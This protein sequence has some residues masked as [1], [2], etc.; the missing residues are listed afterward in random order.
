MSGVLRLLLLAVLRRGGARCSRRASRM[1]DPAAVADEVV[2]TAPAAPADAAEAPADAGDGAPATPVREEQPTARGPD[3]GG[4]GPAADHRRDAPAAGD[5]SRRRRRRP[6]RPIVETAP[7]P[8]ASALPTTPDAP[9][10]IVEPDKLPVALLPVVRTSATAAPAATAPWCADVERAR[11]RTRRRSSAKAAAADTAPAAG[12]SRRAVER[13]TTFR[14]RRSSRWTR[15]QGRSPVAPVG[16]TAIERGPGM[17]FGEESHSTLFS[18][19]VAAPIG[20]VGSGSSLLAVLAGY[21]LPGVG[22]PPASTLIMFILV[23]L[24]VA[25]ARAPRPQLSERAHD[26]RP[27]G[28]RLRPRPGGLPTRLARTPRHTCARQRGRHRRDIA[29][30]AAPRSGPA[31][32]LREMWGTTRCSRCGSWFWDPRAPGAARSRRPSPAWATW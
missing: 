5:A 17:P 31:H 18:E 28:R 26:R 15:T 30:R 25:I 32:N 8:G 4:P 13:G 9:K 29:S 14:A 20:A 19:S 27:A 24:I 12:R 3:H 1:A 21:V 10:A 7:P 2:T 11:S 6:R 16:A 23:G 22:G